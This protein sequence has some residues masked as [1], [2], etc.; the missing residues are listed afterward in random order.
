[1]DK[2]IVQIKEPTPEKSSWSQLERDMKFGKHLYQTPEKFKSINRM[3]PDQLKNSLS[4]SEKK[5]QITGQLRGVYTSIIKE[6][7][8]AILV[9]NY[10]R[11][12]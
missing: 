5:F 4:D 3:T 7:A 10:G 6:T 11:A 9:S 8:E 1:M 2:I 12:W